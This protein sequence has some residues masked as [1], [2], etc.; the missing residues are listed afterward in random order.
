MKDPALG[1]FSFDK[2]YRGKHV[3][4]MCNPCQVCQDMVQPA[5][6]EDP[7]QEDEDGQGINLHLPPDPD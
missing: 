5:R 1:S 6:Q 7:A 3:Y 2:T 4:Y